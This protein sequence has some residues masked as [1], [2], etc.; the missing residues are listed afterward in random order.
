LLNSGWFPWYWDHC[1]GIHPSLITDGETYLGDNVPDNKEV[2]NSISFHHTPMQRGAN[3][4]SF[5]W[6]KVKPIVFASEEKF[7]IEVSNIIRCRINLT[8]PVPNFGS[9][10]YNVPHVDWPDLDNY[11]T[12]LYY[13]DDSDGDTF[14]FNE[15]IDDGFPNTVT[16]DQRISPKS[17]MAL[18]VDGGKY[19]ASSNPVKSNKRITINFNIELK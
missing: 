11:F 12:L 18:L 6:D 19:H 4:A 15:H 16:I 13:L 5:I 1:G 7:G 14:I 9:D 2:R 8:C 17:N 10:N 3:E